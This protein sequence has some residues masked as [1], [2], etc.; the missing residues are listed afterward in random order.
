MGASH[1]SKMR[2]AHKHATLNSARLRFRSHRLS[3]LGER[4]REQEKEKRETQSVDALSSER[5]VNL[6]IHHSK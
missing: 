3:A 4:T 6:D 5:L 2:T 1:K